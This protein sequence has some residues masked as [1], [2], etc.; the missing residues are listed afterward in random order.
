M[1][2]T[3]P[4]SLENMQ[5]PRVA[6]G[7]A[8][9]RLGVVLFRL[10]RRVWRERKPPEKKNGRANSLRARLAPRISR[11]QLFHGLFTVSFDGQSRERGTTRSLRLKQFLRF[12]NS[13]L[14]PRACALKHTLPSY[15]PSCIPTLY[16]GKI[17]LTLIAGW[18]KHFTRLA[19]LYM[20]HPITSCNTKR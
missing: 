17:E 15:R 19:T 20:L 1:W 4:E 12:F 3:W 14:F 11:N 2:C 13:V 7:C 16:P 18:L 8:S 10:V 6:L 9:S 5:E